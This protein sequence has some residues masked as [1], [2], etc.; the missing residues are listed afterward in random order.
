MTWQLYALIAA[1]LWAV[2]NVF[3][4][5]L[6]SKYIKNPLVM[7]SLTGFFS[8]GYICI[9]YML[10]LVAPMFAVHQLFAIVAG[11]A[12]IVSG[13]F[14]FKAIAK[15]D[16]SQMVPL[17]YVG[18]LFT[19]LFAGLFLGEVFTVHTYIGI[20]LILC[21]ALLISPR[22]EH[23]RFTFHKAFWFMI[24]AALC[25]SIGNILLKGVLDSNTFWTSMFYMNIGQLA[26]VC[27]MVW[28]SW[29]DIVQVYKKFGGKVFALLGLV[30]AFDYTATI[31]FFGAALTGYITLVNALSSVQ[32]FFLLL[33]MIVLSR[34]FPHIVEES[35][36]RKVLIQKGIAIVCMFIGVYIIS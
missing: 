29:H 9:V 32:P 36:E 26:I 5:I 27:G 30:E 20:G 33:F 16:V 10:G 13:I 21:G 15:H 6:V 22:L 2:V 14:Y 23:T 18:P 12:Y 7:F 11:M 8:I 24:A 19:A 4:K 3:D 25:V 34:F 28:F 1:C 31:F 17:F 35:L